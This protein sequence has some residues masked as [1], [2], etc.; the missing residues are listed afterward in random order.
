MAVDVFG[1]ARVSLL[2][3]AE[4]AAV[5]RVAAERG[6]P[7]RLLMENAGRAAAAVVDRLFPRGR[8][9][10]LVGSGN[11][12]G[13]ALVMLRALRTWGREVA[14]VPVGS[15]DPDLSLLHGYDIPRVDAVHA[16]RVLPAVEL[17]VDGVLGTGATGAPRD[18]AARAI[19]WINASGRP[20][21]SL[22]IPSGV[23]ATTGQVPAAAVAADVTVT[24]GW[25]KRG[26]LLHPGRSYCGRIIAVEIGFPPWPLE[27][28]AG[29]ELVTPAWAAARLTARPANAHKGTAGRLL[30]LAGS[31]GMAGA[32]ALSAHAAVRAGTGLVRVASPGPNRV[33]LQTYVPEAIFVDRDNHASLVAA[34][35]DASAVVAGPGLGRDGNA[36]SALERV[37]EVTTGRP[38]LL[39][40]DALNLLSPADGRLLRVSSSRPLV[41][42]PHPGEMSRLTGASVDDI[43]ASPIE[44]AES[45]ANALKCTVLLKGA[46]SVV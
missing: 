40:A 23:D 8:V 39:D 33:V 12:G 26:L 6:I 35:P 3:A 36:L 46:P 4:S 20:V 43:L 16:A 24:F 2:T 17:V 29:A 44:A 11:N 37:L 42:T 22:D 45:L 9:V 30:I 10:A 41:L 28:P 18:G 1:R 5:D 34:C 27:Q 31:A 13:D 21:I 7:G 14:Y 32:A 38:T 15:R 25:P 19:E